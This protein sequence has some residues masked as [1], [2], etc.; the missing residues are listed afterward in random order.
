MRSNRSLLLKMTI[1][2]R[3]QPSYR[4]LRSL[5]RLSKFSP[6]WLVFACGLS[7]AYQTSWSPPQLCFALLFFGRTLKNHSPTRT[8]TQVPSSIQL[9]APSMTSGK[10]QRSL[11]ICKIFLTTSTRL[12][13]SGNRPT[14]N[15]ISI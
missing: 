14:N 2:P 4:W 5:H 3:N 11:Q 10:L 8:S 15:T 1:S 12:L 9:S 7:Q 13:I 6:W